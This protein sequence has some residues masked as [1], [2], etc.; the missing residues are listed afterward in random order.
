MKKVNNSIKIMILV[1]YTIAIF[2]VA[3]LIVNSS[4]K[5]TKRFEGYSSV[6]YNDDITLNVQV[7]ENRQSTKET[8]T[9]YEYSKY[10]VYLFVTKKIEGDITDLY[11]YLS[12]KSGKNYSYTET[13]T[14]KSIKGTASYQS[15][16]ISMLNSTTPFAYVQVL[17]DDDGNIK[18][19]NDKA[20]EEMY[21]KVSYKV[22]YSGEEKINE[23]ELNYKFSFDDLKIKTSEFEKY[24]AREIGTTYIKGQDDKL[25][26][27]VY[28]TVTDAT[29]TLPAFDNFKISIV[30]TNA[31]NMEA[32]TTI[33]KIDMS[34]Y[35]VITNKNNITSKYFDEYV[36]LFYYTGSVNRGIRATR[37]ATISQ[38]YGIEK[39]YFTIN[40]ELN[41]GKTYNY[42]YYVNVNDLAQS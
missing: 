1:L 37:T 24:E 25:N 16:A 23:K 12:S 8:K 32:N 14:S 38:E 33:N 40:V 4:N 27:K 28:K 41:N 31:D 9:D 39:L 29:S 6:P 7:L 35:G 13:A 18:E 11:V 26:I 42:K 5:Q 2:V 17:V 36:R 10:D 3:I 34:V 22:Q 19:V 30:D 15:S 21:V 20:P